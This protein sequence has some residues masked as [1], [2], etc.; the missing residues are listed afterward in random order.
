MY[1]LPIE[2]CI[3]AIWNTYSSV[4]LKKIFGILYIDFL[5]NFLFGFNFLFVVKLKEIKYFLNT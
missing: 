1:I 2:L 4:L 3:S 5:F